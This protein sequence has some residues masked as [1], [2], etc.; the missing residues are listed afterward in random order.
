MKLAIKWESDT[1]KIPFA[2]PDRSI[3]FYSGTNN[4]KLLTR[5]EASTKYNTYIL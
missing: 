1:H 5:N 2:K 4:R 3:P